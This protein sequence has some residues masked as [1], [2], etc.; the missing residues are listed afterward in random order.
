MPVQS[1]DFETGEL[2]EIGVDGCGFLVVV[3]GFG[4]VLVVVVFFVVGRLV[5]LLVVVDVVVGFVVAFV[6]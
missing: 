5:G 6:V 3:V 1:R 2:I 4:V